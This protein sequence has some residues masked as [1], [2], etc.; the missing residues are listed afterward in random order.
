M[1]FA[2]EHKMLDFVAFSSFWVPDVDDELFCPAPVFFLD[3]PPRMY[4]TLIFAISVELI[5]ACFS[6]MVSR[7]LLPS[8]TVRGAVMLVMHIFS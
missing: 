2:P 4:F 6:L 3:V 7:V 5:D 8:S 1:A